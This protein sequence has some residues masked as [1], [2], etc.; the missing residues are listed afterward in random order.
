[1][2]RAE[3]ISIHPIFLPPSLDATATLASG[4]FT[5]GGQRVWARYTAYLAQGS[6]CPATRDH[7]QRWPGA[8]MEHNTFVTA[9]SRPGLH[10]EILQMSNAVDQALISALRM[11]TRQPGQAG[12]PV[13]QR[14]TRSQDANRDADWKSQLADVLVP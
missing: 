14:R 6:R 13:L 11:A 8:L 7:R 10:H 5:M 12:S 1:M 4:E 3:N 9:K 2:P